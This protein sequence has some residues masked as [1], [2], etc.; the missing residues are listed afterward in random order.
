MRFSSTKCANIYQ[1][2]MTLA[3]M[4]QKLVTNLDS[5]SQ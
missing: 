3:L 4:E 2:P 5:Q 1:F